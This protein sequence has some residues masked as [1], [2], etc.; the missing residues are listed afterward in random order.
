MINEHISSI[1]YSKGQK[2]A[3]NTGVAANRNKIKQF[4]PGEEYVFAVS[5]GKYKDGDT[6]PKINDTISYGVT[7]PDAYYE[8]V[9]VE[10][11]G[12]LA[13]I[14]AEEAIKTFRVDYLNNKI[15]KHLLNPSYQGLYNEVYNSTYENKKNEYK[16][17][18][19][20]TTSISSSLTRDNW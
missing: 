12:E 13:Y 3:I 14:V 18:Y 17:R 7:P 9:E 4:S 15:K 20:R 19:L 5:L 16:N 2:V 1:R 11:S 6:P 8:F 10:N